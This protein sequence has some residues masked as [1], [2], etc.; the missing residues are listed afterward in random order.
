MLSNLKKRQ[1]TMLFKSKS[2]MPP[3]SATAT[4]TLA[5]QSLQTPSHLC[6]HLL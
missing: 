2:Q 3:K 4:A 6:H 5:L 1:N